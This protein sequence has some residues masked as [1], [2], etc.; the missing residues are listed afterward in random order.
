MWPNCS[1]FT[2]WTSLDDSITWQVDV[3]APGNFKVK[4]YYTCKEGD[5][6]STFKLSVGKS[7]LIAKIVEAH[8]PPI[9][10]MDED[11]APRIESY[12]KDWKVADIGEIELKEGKALMR[13]MALEKPGNTVM[14]FRLMLFE[15]VE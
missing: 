7:N 8:D 15:R 5:E 10:G 11:L 2:N 14:D 3:P 13:L 4:L 6:G 9:R 12:V 1:Y